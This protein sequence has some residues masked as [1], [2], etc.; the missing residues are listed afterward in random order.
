ML[1]PCDEKHKH[2][3]TWV[4]KYY[5]TYSRRRIVVA[6]YLVLF[7]EPPGEMETGSNIENALKKLRDILTVFNW[8]KDISLIAWIVRR[9]EKLSFRETGIL[10]V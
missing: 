5:G 7:F 8:G 2:S 4:S 10:L 3:L 9:F 1:P 6:L